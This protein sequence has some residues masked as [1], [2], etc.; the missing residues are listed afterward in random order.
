LEDAADM[1]PPYLQFVQDMASCF[2]TL[3]EYNGKLTLMDSIL[4]LQAFR[5]KI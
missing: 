5:F 2:I 4:R 1:A 3:T